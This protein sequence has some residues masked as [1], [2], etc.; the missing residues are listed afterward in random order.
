MPGLS[1]AA[2]R[3]EM[4]E[5]DRSHDGRTVGVAIGELFRVLLPENP[6]TGYRWELQSAPDPILCLEED[7]FAR[8]STAPGASGL[9]SWRFRAIRAGVVRLGLALKR[10]W[11][12]RAIETFTIDI[13]VEAP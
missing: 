5:I 11:Q 8:S 1:T 13:R 6:S 10:S 3:I 12:P 9:R 7:S 2:G 4:L